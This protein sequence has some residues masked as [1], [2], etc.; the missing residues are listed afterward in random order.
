LATINDRDPFVLHHIKLLMIT[1][2][3]SLSQPINI[4]GNGMWHIFDI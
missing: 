2:R 3:M 4:V 1:N